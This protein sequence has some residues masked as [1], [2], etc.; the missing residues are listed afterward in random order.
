VVEFNASDVRNKKMF[1]AIVGDL[2]SNHSMAEYFKSDEKGEK[3]GHHPPMNNNSNNNN[4]KTC[5]VMDEVDGMSGN[6][7]R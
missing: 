5:I 3:Q 1:K 7:D 6:A 4:D 2:S